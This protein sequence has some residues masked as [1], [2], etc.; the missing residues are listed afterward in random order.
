MSLLICEKFGQLGD[1]RKEGFGGWD[2]KTLA[3]VLL[4]AAFLQ[5]AC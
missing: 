1:H 2:E 3:T 5:P 4:K